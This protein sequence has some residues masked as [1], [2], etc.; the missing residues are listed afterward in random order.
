M[1]FIFSNVPI[2]IIV[3]LGKFLDYDSII[4]LNQTMYPSDRIVHRRFTKNE[5]DSHEAQA[6]AQGKK[7]LLDKFNYI[8]DRDLKR[9]VQKK[10][11]NLLE[12]L[13]TFRKNKRAFHIVKRNSALRNIIILKCKDVLLAAEER[14]IFG[15]TFTN[16]YR[17]KLTREAAGLVEEINEIMSLNNNQPSN[18]III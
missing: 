10:C 5:V 17:S 13:R 18:R 14:R 6:I 1:V 2:D 7:T 12:I 9:M 15:G 3:Y 16:Y 11:K 8:Y 4:N